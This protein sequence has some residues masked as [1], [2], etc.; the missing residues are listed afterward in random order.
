MPEAG[1]GPSCQM[2]PTCKGARHTTWLLPELIMQAAVAL[3]IS[4][5]FSLKAFQKLPMKY[6]LD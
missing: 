5:A 3:S 2:H 6:L 4:A 1:A